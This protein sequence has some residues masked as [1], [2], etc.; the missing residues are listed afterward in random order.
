MEGDDGEQVDEHAQGARDG[1]GPGQVPDRVL[2]FLDNKVEAVPAGEGEQAGVEGEGEG[3][4]VSLRVVPGEV[5][6]PAPAQLH[7]PRGHD[8]DQGDHLGVGEVVLDHVGQADRVAVDKSDQTETGRGHQTVTME[9][10]FNIDNIVSRYL[11]IF[12]SYRVE[13]SG[14]SHSAKRGF[15]M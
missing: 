10:I 7:H 4:G 5:L 9:R 13:S 1:D 12:I 6:H 14:G 15:R 8:D 2:H 11:R 3:G